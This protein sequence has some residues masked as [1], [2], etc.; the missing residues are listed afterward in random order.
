MAGRRA[1]GAAP[2]LDASSTVLVVGASLAGLWACEALRRHGFAGRIVLLGD[3]ARLPYDRPPLS[4]QYLAGQWDAGRVQLRTRER[5]DELDLELRLGERAAALDLAQRA[6]AL[7]DGTAVAFD[8]LVVATGAAARPWPRP[9]PSGVRTL[10]RVEDSDALRDALVGGARRLVVVGG[11]FL[12]MEVAA[13]ARALGSEV[14]VV[15]PLATPLGRVAG[16]V[17]G[18]AVRTLHEAHGVDVRTGTSV[19]GFAGAERVEGVVVD[20]GETIAAD[21]VLVAI[22]VEPETAWLEGSGVTL[23]RG[24][25]CDAT[26]AAAPGVVAAGDVARFPHPLAAAPVRLEHWTNAAEHGTHAAA[27]LLAPPGLATAYDAVPYFWSDQFGVKIQAVGLPGPDDEVVVVDGSVAS[28]RFVACH[29]RDGALVA[30]S[31]VGMPRRLMA[32]RALLE[33]PSSLDDALALAASLRS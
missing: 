9:A 21:V 25:V 31:C 1:P 33:R 13:T 4:K 19:A 8:G 12:G 18:E 11:G 20:G 15:E 27:T 2:G 7:E 3:E 28:A 29:A 6:V 17:L 16:P 5:I 10:R 24:V 14:T 23:D 22:G 32:F 30:A 26:L